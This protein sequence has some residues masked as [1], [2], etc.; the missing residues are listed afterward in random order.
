M[1]KGRKESGMFNLNIGSNLESGA[2]EEGLE[3]MII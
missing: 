2:T 1:K 3:R